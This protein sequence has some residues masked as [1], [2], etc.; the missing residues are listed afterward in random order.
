MCSLKD[1]PHLLIRVLL[2]SSLNQSYRI[3]LPPLI[4]SQPGWIQAQG[5]ED[6]EH[7]E[8]A[9]DEEETHSQANDQSAVV[10]EPG[11]LCRDHT[12]HGMVGTTVGCG[13]KVLA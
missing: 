12:S 7:A 9:A 6:D 2:K 8:E 11:D 5:S 13:G 3:R 1:L 4:A 10:L